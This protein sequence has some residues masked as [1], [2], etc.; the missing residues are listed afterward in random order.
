M[1]KNKE[2]HNAQ[3]HIPKF[4]S[5]I[6]RSHQ[7]KGDRLCWRIRC[8]TLGFS[9]QNQL[10]I[11]GCLCIMHINYIYTIRTILSLSINIRSNRSS[12]I[13]YRIRLFSYVLRFWFGLWPA[14]PGPNLRTWTGDSVCD[15]TLRIKARH[16]KKEPCWDS[17][18]NRVNIFNIIIIDFTHQQ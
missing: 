14:G 13:I 9:L 8:T 2:S 16:V 5:L 11:P 4:H 12:C 17:E 15:S 3:R 1:I 18:S 7:S 6:D 10:A